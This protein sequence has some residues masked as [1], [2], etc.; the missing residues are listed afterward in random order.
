MGTL[1][2]TEQL[3]SLYG[4]SAMAS[5]YFRTGDWMAVSVSPWL[6]LAVHGCGYDSTGDGF[7]FTKC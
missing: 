2:K 7:P 5:I 6:E 1:E 3:T 4:E